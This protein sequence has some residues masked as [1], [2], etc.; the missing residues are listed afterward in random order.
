MLLGLITFHS[1]VRFMGV[2][3][4]SSNLFNNS[5][6]LITLLNRRSEVTNLAKSF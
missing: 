3:E 1:A 6:F 2:L 5:S 4:L